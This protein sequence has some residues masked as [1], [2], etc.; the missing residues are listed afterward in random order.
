[1]CFTANNKNNI[2]WILF[3]LTLYGFLIGDR[4][5]KKKIEIKKESGER[6]KK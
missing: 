5:K 6:K 2:V 1:M 3:H 4:Q